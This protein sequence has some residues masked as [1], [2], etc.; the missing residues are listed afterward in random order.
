MH[1]KSWIRIHIYNIT[2]SAIK[3]IASANCSRFSLPTLF[4]SHSVLQN[5]AP[6]MLYI[7]I[8]E[9]CHTY[10]MCASIGCGTF[11]AINNGLTSSPET[12]PSWSLSMPVKYVS[13]FA[14]C[15]FVTTQELSVA[16]AAPA[17]AFSGGVRLGGRDVGRVPPPLQIDIRYIACDKQQN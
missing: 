12:N 8:A 7:R 16:A 2:F 15:S 4:V 11:E 6:P 10:Q 5:T 9:D 3:Y 1:V 17:S 13:Y 14:L